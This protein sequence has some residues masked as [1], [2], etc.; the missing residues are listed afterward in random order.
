VNT[1]ESAWDGSA[2][3]FSNVFPQADYQADAVNSFLKSNKLPFSSYNVSAGDSIGAKGGVFNKGGRGYPDV[4]AN[5]AQ[6][7]AFIAGRLESSWGTSLAAPI[8]G[9]VITL[10]RNLSTGSTKDSIT[11]HGLDQ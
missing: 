5:G 1:P 9:G 3:G 8:W 6:F 4:S 10:V 11:D 2:G 7:E